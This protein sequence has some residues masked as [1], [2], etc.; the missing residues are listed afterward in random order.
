MAEN[1]VYYYMRLK[2]GFFESKELSEVESMPDGFLYSNILLKMYLKS[3]RD[4]GRLMAGTIPYSEDMI[5]KITGHKKKTVKKALE[6]FKNVGLIEVLDNGAIYMLDIQNFI[7]KS[8]T[9]GERKKAYRE[10]IKAE[11]DGH[12]SGQP[13][14]R[15]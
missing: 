1:K 14:T 12:L 8:S 5:A 10:R 4:E 11:K 2:E 3:L 13:S 7:G 6:I 15:D 9:E